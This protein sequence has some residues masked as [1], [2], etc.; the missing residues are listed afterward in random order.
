MSKS[1]FECQCNLEEEKK[2][3]TT[4]SNELATELNKSLVAQLEAKSNEID[5]LK[6]SVGRLEAELEAR[7]QEKRSLVNSET[8]T[9]NTIIDTASIRQ[10]IELAPLIAPK[11]T[12]PLDQQ[13]N[14]NKKKNNETDSL[15]DL[16]GN[17]MNLIKGFSFLLN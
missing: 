14:Q 9:T 5:E 10:K 8:N 16:I 15:E 17:Y 13:T 11:S 6:R 3:T 7:N 2:E 1:D 4:N 12:S